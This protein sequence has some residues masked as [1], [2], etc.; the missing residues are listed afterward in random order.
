MRIRFRDV[1]GIIQQVG[2]ELSKCGVSIYSILQNPI[3]DKN[4]AYFVVMTDPVE[5]GK[6]KEACV[7]IESLDWCL[8][9]TFYMP[10]L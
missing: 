2:E 5:V 10:V 4:D 7:R 8:G 9:N 1:T 3:E 6:I